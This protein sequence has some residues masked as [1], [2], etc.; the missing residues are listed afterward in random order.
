M[1]NYRRGRNI[2]KQERETNKKKKRMNEGI[3]RY[4]DTVVLRLR[5]DR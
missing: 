1:N 5:E 3:E 2:R 4:Q